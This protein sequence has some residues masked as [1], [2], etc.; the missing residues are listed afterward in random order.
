[1]ETS[2]D[3][4]HKLHAEIVC[5]FDKLTLSFDSAQIQGKVTV[6]WDA[7]LPS[8]FLFLASILPS[9]IVLCARDA[10]PTCAGLNSEPFP[11]VVVLHK[12]S[13]NKRVYF[14]SISHFSPKKVSKPSL[15]PWARGKKTGFLRIK[16][17]PGVKMG[18]ILMLLLATSLSRV[19][20]RLRASPIR[21]DETFKLKLILFPVGEISNSIHS[22]QDLQHEKIVRPSSRRFGSK[23]LFIR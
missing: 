17:L 4:Q 19:I 2:A 18:A 5:L 22:H 23:L 1:M 12:K 10:P 16:A 21:F 14:R 13:L 15:N 11:V 6:P 3:I 9:W 7:A 8:S 20:P